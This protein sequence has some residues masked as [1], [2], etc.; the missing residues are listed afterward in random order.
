M[1]C[2]WYLFHWLFHIF[3]VWV[4][5]QGPHDP[6]LPGGPLSCQSARDLKVSLTEH[7][8]SINSS[9]FGITTATLMPLVPFS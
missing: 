4:R 8:K 5:T 3:W 2:S 7:Q 1:R 6:L 9:C